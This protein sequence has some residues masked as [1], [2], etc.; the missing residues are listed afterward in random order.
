M[1]FYLGNFTFGVNYYNDNHDDV[2]EDFVSIPGIN[3][4][5]S[6]LMNYP[7]DHYRNLAN[8]KVAILTFEKGNID[9]QFRSVGENNVTIIIDNYSTGQNIEITC[10]S[11][12]MKYYFQQM[13]D[14]VDAN[15]N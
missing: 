6:D 8:G 15:P 5:K 7:S 1:T 10:P 12:Q 2:I 13:A 9:I 4:T 11:Y 3:L 14:V